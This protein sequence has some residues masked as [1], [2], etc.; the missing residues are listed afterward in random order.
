MAL[1]GGLLMN[2][3]L[4]P[5]KL[6][7]F[8]DEKLHEINQSL[9]QSLVDATTALQD[10]APYESLILLQTTRRVLKTCK[11]LNMGGKL[12]RSSLE[13]EMH[14]LSPGQ[15]LILHVVEQNAGVLIYRRSK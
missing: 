3:V 1:D 6:P 11:I 4:L 14:D 5:P 2:H 8:R 9:V 12:D 15:M 13:R 7:G 10:A